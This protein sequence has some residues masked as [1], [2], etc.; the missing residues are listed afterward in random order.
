MDERLPGWVRRPDH[1]LRQEADRYR[2]MSPEERARHLAAVCR[3]AMRLVAARP[4]ADRVR[5]RR[6]PLPESSRAVLARLR[7][8]GGRTGPGR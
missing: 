8:G 4:D 7:E 2:G 5:R 6:D 1:P 3:D